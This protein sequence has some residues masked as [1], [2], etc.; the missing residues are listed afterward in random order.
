[1]TSTSKLAKGRS[2]PKP[3][4]CHAYVPHPTRQSEA[5]HT[6]ISFSLELSSHVVMYWRLRQ[7]CD[8]QVIHAWRVLAKSLCCTML[9]CL[10][11]TF[12]LLLSLNL[13]RPL[14]LRIHPTQLFPR[15]FL[16]DSRKTATEWVCI[17][18]R[19]AFSKCHLIN[20][21]G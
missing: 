1:M 14:L 16:G 11:M 19:L 10:K 21:G 20:S 4:F 8:W 13:R 17:L 3:S 5:Q 6:S 12:I 7:V 18:L 9:R 2:H 15:V